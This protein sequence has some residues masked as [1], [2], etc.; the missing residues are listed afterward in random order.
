MAA[1]GVA[2]ANLI[3]MATQFLSSDT[4]KTVVKKSFSL[5]KALII[6]A[7][8]LA[9]IIVI[10]IVVLLIVWIKAYCSCIQR[11]LSCGKNGN[12]TTSNGTGC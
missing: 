9:V 4:G 7:I 10:V 12:T 11:I 1:A 6:G 2:A 3:P 5:A 8:I